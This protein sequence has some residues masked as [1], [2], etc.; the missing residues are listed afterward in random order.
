MSQFHKRLPFLVAVALLASFGLIFYFAIDSL[1]KEISTPPRAARNGQARG[2]MPEALKAAAAKGDI[3][4]IKLE[5]AKGG[6][7]NMPYP[8]LEGRR[9]ITLLTYAA[10]QGDAN[11]IKALIAA[12]AKPGT[13]SDDWG[14]PLMMA[15]AKGD[16]A[17][18]SELL[19]AGAK[20][21]ERNKF[22]ETAL[23]MAV[24]F[25]TDERARAL[26]EAGANVNLADVDGTT[27]LAAAS[28]GD[29][30]AAIVRTLLDSKA[31]VDAANKDGV[32]PLMLAAKQG[33]LEKC[34]LLLDAGAKATL[35]DSNNWTAL[36][37]ARQRSDDSG[38]KCASYLAQANR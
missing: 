32:T 19:K 27:P 5:L 6:D 35:K 29:A 4:A 36:D 24:R 25:G 1:N 12:G 26:I 37:W 38:N 11:L 21:D 2:F 33:D 13:P 9:Q 23:M 28:G 15:A 3:N 34:V 31:D 14:T 18:I 16:P 8:I 20:V 17:S 10:M 22:G 30:S 7:I